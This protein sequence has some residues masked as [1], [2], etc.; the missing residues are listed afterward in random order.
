ML[1]LAMAEKAVCF[2]RS[3]S[4]VF[5]TRRVVGSSSVDNRKF[6][7]RRLASGRESEAKS[8]GTQRLCDLVARI[9][10]GGVGFWRCQRRGVGPRPPSKFGLG[11]Q[12]NPSSFP[13][14]ADESSSVKRRCRNKSSERQTIPPLRNE[15]SEVR[16]LSN[17]RLVQDFFLAFSGVPSVEEL[18]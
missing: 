9:A 5:Q 17:L 2:L 4:E 15:P 1:L 8:T 16:A 12:F 13:G 14:A 6:C 3:V 7:H 11:C 18:W 10:S